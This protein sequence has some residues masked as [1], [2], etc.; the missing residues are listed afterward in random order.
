MD[1]TSGAERARQT[2]HLNL[3]FITR[4]IDLSPDSP[5]VSPTDTEFHGSSEQLFGFRVF[6]GNLFDISRKDLKGLSPKT[7]CLGTW[8]LYAPRFVH[9]RAPRDANAEVETWREA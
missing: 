4:V 3:A 9:S 7:S 5:V 2:T 8:I 1:R 6:K